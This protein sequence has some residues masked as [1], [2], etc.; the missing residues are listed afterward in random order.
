MTGSVADAP[1]V[2]PDAVTTEVIICVVGGTDDAEIIEV[3]T[4]V[5]LGCNVVVESLADRT[6]DEMT[7]ATDEESADEREEEMAA[8][9]VLVL[10]TEVSEVLETVE[11]SVD[12]EV[13]MVLR[14]R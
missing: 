11:V 7:D 5:E 4:W 2:A 10:D 1:S 3:T 8:E 14:R 9:S 13:L 12:G 6:D